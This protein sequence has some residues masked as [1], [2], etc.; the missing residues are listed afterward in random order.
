MTK[1]LLP[2]DLKRAVE[3]VA[4]EIGFQRLCWSTWKE[5]VGRNTNHINSI[6]KEKV[7]MGALSFKLGET[8]PQFLQRFT[9]IVSFGSQPLQLDFDENTDEKTLTTTLTTTTLMTTKTLTRNVI[10]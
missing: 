4:R 8:I 9:R 3:D 6:T 10:V 1:R 5:L 2:S 7:E